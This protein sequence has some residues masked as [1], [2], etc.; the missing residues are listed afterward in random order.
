MKKKFNL[1]PLFCISSVSLSLVL[2]SCGTANPASVAAGTAAAAMSETVPAGS[3]S[4]KEESAPEITS[5]AAPSETTGETDITGSE[6]TPDNPEESDPAV[7]ELTA[8]DNTSL[9]SSDALPRAAAADA[10]PDV[11]VVPVTASQVL[12]AAGTPAAVSEPETAAHSEASTAG[13][14]AADTSENP[15]TLPAAHDTVLY[16]AGQNRYL[17]YG[18][19]GS[20]AP[21]GK[22]VLPVSRYIDQV[23]EGAPMGCEAASLLMALW[24]K[25]YCTDLSYQQFLAA[26][27]YASDGNPNHGFVGT[28]YANDGVFD[29]INM[30]A[31]AS[32]GAR[33]A[34]AADIT[35]CSEEDLLYQLYLG[36]PVVV[37]TSYKFGPTAPEA[38]WWG[39]YKTNAHVMLLCGFD[40][41]TRQFYIADPAPGGAYSGMVWVSWETFT[42]SFDVMRGAV[43]VW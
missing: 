30:P 43:A 7:T 15:E 4:A 3:L 39:N 34:S 33:Y 32:W 38:Y 35:G 22:T 25:G 17:V 1:I 19:D 2:T 41:D 11:P 40:P 29:G 13:Q 9:F 24:S 14:S 8:D 6:S 36:H 28:P 21:L 20:A 42:D 37:W 5:R 31:V 16:D 23:A 26:M 12:T 27:P 18:S 10:E